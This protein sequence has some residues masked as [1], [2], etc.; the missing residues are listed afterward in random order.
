[1]VS[2]GKWVGL[3]IAVLLV[4]V[5]LV[6]NGSV[7]ANK[8]PKE[9]EGINGYKTKRSRLSQETW[10]FANCYAARIER[11]VGWALLAISLAGMLYLKG[12]DEG[13]TGS[14]STE[15]ICVQMCVLYFAVILPTE[16][17]LKKNFD[18]SGR[19]K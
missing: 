1:M 8:A 4:P 15:I 12:K 10:E 6:I 2:L 16:A 14:F 17:A 5:F 3:L 18:E 19:R 13:S 9:M 11:V 7:F